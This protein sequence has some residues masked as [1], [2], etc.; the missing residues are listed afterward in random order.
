MFLKKFLRKKDKNNSIIHAKRKGAVMEI[1]IV[2]DEKEIADLIEIYLKNE[3][4]TIHKY[5][6][7]KEVVEN[8]DNLNIDLALIDVMMPEIDG[9][10][11]CRKLREKYNFPILFVT[12][13]IEDTD[14]INGLTLGADDYI[15]KPFE[16]LELV[17]RVKANLR[18]YKEY[19]KQLVKDENKIDFRNIV[20]NN[21][22]HEFFLN[23]KQIDLTPIE[24]SILWTLCKNRGNVVKTDVLFFEVWKEKYFEQDNN[25]VMVHIRHLREK[26]CDNTK[27]PKYIKTI[28]GVGYKIEK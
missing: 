23:E 7:S 2:D 5:Y 28:W 9:F 16:P 12:A 19:N 20:I 26:L 15:T 27:N 10:S 25:T 24:F 4:Y 18:R 1:L 3:G 13:K 6:S 22:T 17:A 14:K 8:L 21:N 11:L